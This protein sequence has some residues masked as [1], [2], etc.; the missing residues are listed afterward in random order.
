MRKTLPLLHVLFLTATA[1]GQGVEPP[2][3]RIVGGEDVL[4]ADEFPF[5]AKIIYDGFKVGCTGSLVAPDKVLTAGHCVDRYR[6]RKLSVGFGNIR[7]ENPPLPPPTGAPGQYRVEK[8]LHP[9]YCHPSRT[10]SL[11]SVLKPLL[12]ISSPFAF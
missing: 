8:I 1:S 4:T 3:K 10:I 11:F 6:A 12:K 9:E 5:V 7:A 2:Q